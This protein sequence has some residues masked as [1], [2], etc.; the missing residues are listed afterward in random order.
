[1]ADVLE[2]EDLLSQLTAEGQ[3]QSSGSFTVDLSR[4]KDKLA[5]FQFEDPFYYILKLVQAAVAGDA[6]EF[7]V[8]SG[9]SE[10]AVAILGLGFSRL[11]MENLFY[12]LVGEGQSDAAPALRHFAMGVNAAVSTRASEITV[13]TFD[14]QAGVEVRW[15]KKGQTSVGWAPARPFAQ[16]RFLMKRTAADMLSDIGAKLA[17]RDLFSMFSGDRKG[18]DREQGL[19]YDHCAFSPMPISINGRPCPGYDLGQPAQ[20]GLW[21]NLVAN[22]FQTRSLHPKYHLYEVFLP[23]TASPGLAGPRRSFSSW[24]KGYV[25]DGRFSTIMV[26]PARL[27]EFVTVM[28]IRDGL[29]LKPLRLS[30]DG[31]GAILYVDAAELDVDLTETQLT[32]NER[33]LNQFKEM[34]RAVREAG[35]HYL[36][37]GKARLPSGLRLQLE[38]KLRGAPESS[39]VFN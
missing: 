11:Q 31:P 25:K 36:E 37:S 13:Q 26:V 6:Q 27:G 14:G 35:L 9:T 30:W 16:T 2:V 34:G 5:R 28:P 20:V 12:C 7:S 17:S 4:A 19:I 21:A 8:N 29:S 39:M 18:M 32:R 22:L 1:M 10:V 33:N 24:T 3:L 15:S 23:K 38:S